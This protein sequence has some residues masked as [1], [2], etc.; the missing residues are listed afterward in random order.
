MPCAR[1]Q[2]PTYLNRRGR[3]AAVVYRGGVRTEITLPGKYGSKESKEEYEAILRN[4]GARAAL[5]H[6]TVDMSAMYAR[7][8][9]ET[10]KTVAAGVG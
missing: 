5:G 2:I 6:A 3:G 8:D 9:L 10:A 7:R 4:E 1:Q